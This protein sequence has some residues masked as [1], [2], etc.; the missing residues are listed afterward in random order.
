MTKLL[1]LLT[2]ICMCLIGCPSDPITPDPDPIVDPTPEPEPEPDPE[3]EPPYDPL[4]QC[5][6]EWNTG[7]NY[8]NYDQLIHLV[9]TTIEATSCTADTILCITVGQPGDPCHRVW[10]FEA[11]DDIPRKSLTDECGNYVIRYSEEEL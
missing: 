1:T 3:P 6:V 10:E 7:V 9:A 5:K 11:M 4:Q 8:K 2:I